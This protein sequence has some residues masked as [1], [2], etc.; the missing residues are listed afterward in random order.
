MTIKIP[1]NKDKMTKLEKWERNLEEDRLWNNSLLESTYLDML[2]KRKERLKSK[3]IELRNA[4]RSWVYRKKTPPPRIEVAWIIYSQLGWK[5]YDI[6]E[7]ELWE[8]LPETDPLEIMEICEDIDN[9]NS[10]GIET[11]EPLI[12]EE[13]ILSLRVV[14]NTLA[15]EGIDI[16]KNYFSNNWV[17]AGK[18][19]VGGR[20]QEIAARTKQPWEIEKDNQNSKATLIKKSKESIPKKK[21]ITKRNKTSILSSFFG[22]IKG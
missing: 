15:E 1:I 18:K 7:E 8:D 19:H 16:R 17:R 14:L 3:E 4:M 12:E 2:K 22:I 21:Q 9:S 20:I 11:V 13:T 10:L 5:G 6:D